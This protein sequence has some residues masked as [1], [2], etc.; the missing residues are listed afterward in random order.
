MSFVKVEKRWVPLEIESDWA[1]S[2]KEMTASL[3]AFSAEEFEA[4]KVQIMGA[5]TMFD[6]I[7]TKIASAE[8]QEQ[9]DQSLKEA[10]MPLMSIFMML[11]QA[12][13]AVE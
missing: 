6:G 13:E 2:F 8:T 11:S 12:A 3:K 9:F 1:E 7:L 5:L 4:Q 10:T